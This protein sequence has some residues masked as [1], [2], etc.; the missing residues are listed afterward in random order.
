NDFNNSGFNYRF[1]FISSMTFWDDFQIQ[2]SGYY[3]GR[4]IIPQGYLEPFFN[5]DAGIQKGILKGRGMIR[6]KIT[7]ICNTKTFNLVFEDNNFVQ[8]A[9]WKQETRFFYINFT[10][11]FGKTDHHKSKS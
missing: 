4:T 9:T 5:L 3:R 8:K 2:V 11:R 6:F 1:N 7:D 10:Y